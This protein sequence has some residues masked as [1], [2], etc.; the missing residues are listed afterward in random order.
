MKARTLFNPKYLSKP[1]KDM[2]KERVKKSL[3]PASPRKKKW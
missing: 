1:T 2:L 3:L